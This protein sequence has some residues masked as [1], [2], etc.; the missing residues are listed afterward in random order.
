[1]DF[2]LCISILVWMSVECVSMRESDTLDT[3]YEVFGSACGYKILKNGALQERGWTP[4]SSEAFWFLPSSVLQ[5]VLCRCQSY[6]I[7]LSMN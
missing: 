1:M 2:Y 5:F 7:L 6:E 4:V 3:M